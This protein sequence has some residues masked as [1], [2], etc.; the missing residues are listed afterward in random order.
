M[1]SSMKIFFASVFAAICAGSLTLMAFD[2]YLI[3]VSVDYLSF[4]A[5]T[6]LIVEAALSISRSKKPFF[7]SQVSRAGR[8]AFG[9]SIL[10]IH[11][12]QLIE[13][14]V[15][16]SQIAKIEIN[17]MDYLAL[18]AGIFLIVEGLYKITKADSRDFY[19]Q[20]A[21]LFRVVLG[22]IVVAI[23]IQQFI[24]CR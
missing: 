21:R 5:G 4:A 3:K 19:E 7:P 16:S 15:L 2:T 8:I 11:F 12:N 1:K 23:H 14:S 18:S 20:F 9:A 22:S 10:F 13:H 24:H 6:F 17:Y